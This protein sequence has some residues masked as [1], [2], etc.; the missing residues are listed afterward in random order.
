[1]L[2]KMIGALVGGKLAQNAKNVG[3]PTGAAIG[4]A[5]P[6]LLARMS[7]PAMIAMGVGGYA[8]KKYID[9][10]DAGQPGPTKT[11]ANVASIP[12]PKAT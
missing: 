8:V 7:I 11:S 9:K 12:Q 1:M 4:A 3:G 6:F 10:K 2:T 5:V